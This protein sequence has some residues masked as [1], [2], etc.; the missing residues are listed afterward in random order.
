MLSSEIKNFFYT[1]LDKF[2]DLE[3]IYCTEFKVNATDGMY[4]SVLIKQKISKKVLVEKIE[5]IVDDLT[6]LL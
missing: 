6:N 1:G 3:I 5:F 4:F 2:A